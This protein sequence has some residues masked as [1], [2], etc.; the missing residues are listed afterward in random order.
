MYASFG[1]HNYLCS[2]QA[3]SFQLAEAALALYYS[4]LQFWNHSRK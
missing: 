4:S 1:H 2:Q 3:R